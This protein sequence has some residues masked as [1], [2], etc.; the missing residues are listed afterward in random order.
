MTGPKY[1]SKNNDHPYLGGENFLENFKI[2]K[3]LTLQRAENLAK[4]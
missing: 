1:Y 4:K 2:L 3:R